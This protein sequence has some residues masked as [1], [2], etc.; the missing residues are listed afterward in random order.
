MEKDL[1]TRYSKMGE[2]DLPE[3]ADLEVLGRWI[4]IALT[5][6]VQEVLG[7]LRSQEEPPET[8]I[9]AMNATINAGKYVILKDDYEQQQQKH[10]SFVFDDDDLIVGEKKQK[11]DQQPPKKKNRFYNRR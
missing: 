9:R 11:T 10:N 3:K 8:K 4:D 7:I 5:C 2:M 1:A 6:G